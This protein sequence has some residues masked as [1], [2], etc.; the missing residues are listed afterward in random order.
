MVWAHEIDD[1][2]Q[3]AMAAMMGAP[4]VMVEKLPGGKEVVD[5]FLAL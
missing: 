3:V 1:D 4:T 2:A 5:A